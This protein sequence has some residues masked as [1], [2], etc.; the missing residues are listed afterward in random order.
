[1]YIAIASCI[2]GTTYFL[3]MM[4]IHMGERTCSK[5][6]GLLEILGVACMEKNYTIL[7]NGR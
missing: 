2:M 4:C 6:E 1:M 7:W 5:L 3:H